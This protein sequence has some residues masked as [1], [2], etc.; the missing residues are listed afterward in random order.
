MGG[1]KDPTEL[2]CIR[3]NGAFFTTIEKNCF[4]MLYELFSPTNVCLLQQ[5]T[6]LFGLL[7][8]LLLIFSST[9]P[10]GGDRPR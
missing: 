9:G 5:M 8:S 2:K 6:R 3:K 4:S 7:F 1:R 10:F